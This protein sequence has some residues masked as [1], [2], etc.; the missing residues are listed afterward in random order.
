MYFEDVKQKTLKPETTAASTNIN[1]ML[2]NKE[3]P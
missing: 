1:K 2:R 3:E